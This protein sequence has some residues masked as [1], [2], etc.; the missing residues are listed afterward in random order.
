LE[1]ADG[2]LQLA[3]GNFNIEVFSLHFCGL[4]FCGSTFDILVLLE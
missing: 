2:G 4:S 3:A 1:S